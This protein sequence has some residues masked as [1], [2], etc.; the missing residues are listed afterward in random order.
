MRHLKQ[1]VNRQSV[2][3][4]RRDA[5]AVAVHQLH[6]NIR[7][8][9]GCTGSS[10]DGSSVRSVLVALSCAAMSARKREFSRFIFGTYIS[11]ANDR[12]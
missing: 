5:H 2:A 3:A 4:A 11:I 8:N 1:T 7:G 6:Q 10:I 12:G 9:H